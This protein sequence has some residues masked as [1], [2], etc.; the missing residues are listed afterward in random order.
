MSGKQ[1]NLFVPAAKQK[2]ISEDKTNRN[3]KQYLMMIHFKMKLD[4]KRKVFHLFFVCFR[5]VCPSG[6]GGVLE[7]CCSSSPLDRLPYST[8]PFMSSASLEGE[9]EEPESMNGVFT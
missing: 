7:S 1:G 4:K 9:Q 8:W 3:D 2:N 5:P 6:D